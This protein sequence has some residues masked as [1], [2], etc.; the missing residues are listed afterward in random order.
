MAIHGKHGAANFVRR[1][2]R[3]I[4]PYGGGYVLVVVAVEHEIGIGVGHVVGI[5]DNIV[6]RVPFVI[7]KAFDSYPE[8][9]VALVVLIFH[10][11]VGVYVVIVPG[12]HYHHAPFSWCCHAE[13]HRAVVVPYSAHTGYSAG[14]ILLHGLAGICYFDALC[15]GLAVVC[16]FGFDIVCPVCGEGM[17][18]RQGGLVG[19]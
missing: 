10:K 18:G 19:G 1:V 8:I 2:L 14:V 12:R 4:G 3:H 7:L 15:A 6:V 11:V 5:V 17:L 16:A 13:R 9:A